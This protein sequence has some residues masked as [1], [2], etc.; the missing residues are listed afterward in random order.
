MAFLIADLRIADLFEGCAK[1]VASYL[2]CSYRAVPGKYKMEPKAPGI[3]HPKLEASDSRKN[4]LRRGAKPQR[5]TYP[6]THS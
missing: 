5:L 2:L 6:A 4:I 3:E 1:P